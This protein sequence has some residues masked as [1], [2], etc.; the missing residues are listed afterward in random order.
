MGRAKPPAIIGGCAMNVQ[1]LATTLQFIVDLDSKL[2]LQTNL[3]S[4]RS[5][6][7]QLVQSPAN[8]TQQSNLAVALAAFKEAAEKLGESISPP[9]RALIKELGD[10]RFF[11]PAIAEE[12]MASIA[13]NA[14]TPS[15]ARDFV[16]KLATEREAF[17]AV[18]RSTLEGVKR[19]GV[20]GEPLPAGS[21][22]MAF[23]VPR[24]IFEN[25]L[26]E[27]AA[28]L[29]FLNRLLTN[30][31]EALTGQAEPVDLKNLSSSMPTIIIA[32]GLAAMNAVGNVVNKFLDAWKKAE[33]I[34]EIRER[35]KKAGMRKP[36][37]LT[38]LTE[39]ITTIIEEVAEVST[40]EIIS[41]STV[42]PGRKNELEAAIRRDV[43][44]LFGQLERGLIVEI[45]V[46]PAGPKDKDSAD[47][48][49]EGLRL[50][51]RTLQ[52]PPVSNEPVLLTNGDIDEPEPE[53]AIKRTSTRRESKGTTSK[54]TSMKQDVPVD[55]E[56]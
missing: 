12:V 51:S 54:R 1:T 9:Y 47:P 23:M 39:E 13:S 24:E 44:K 40:T 53:F 19:L 25:H 35:V 36:E 55:G 27:F 43:F 5:S 31:G 8:P 21:A 17:L 16:Q 22:Q 45:R 37:M 50:L 6:L 30:V 3:Q 4:V 11:D 26:G 18:V 33:E 15:V 49:L 32:A 52:F 34:R 2:G 38:S 28:E 7:D 14:M 41:Q 48:N 56:N 20:Q 46:E 42:E 10:D 29:K